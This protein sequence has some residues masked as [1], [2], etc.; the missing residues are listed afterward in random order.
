MCFLRE[1]I[2]TIVTATDARVCC[3]R[4]CFYTVAMITAHPLMNPL[5]AVF[6][7]SHN[8]DSSFSDHDYTD[9]TLMVKDDKAALPDDPIQ[10]NESRSITLMNEANEWE[11]SELITTLLCCSAPLFLLSNEPYISCS[12][13]LFD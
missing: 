8:A 6:F 9:C 10:H 4:D 2:V 5:I 12:A 3:L 1:D 7:I 13:V 11:Q